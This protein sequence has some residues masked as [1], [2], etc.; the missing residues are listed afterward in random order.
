VLAVRIGAKVGTGDDTMTMVT[1]V[2]ASLSLHWI[3]LS[4]DKSSSEMDTSAVAGSA[5]MERRNPVWLRVRE[6]YR[7]VANFANLV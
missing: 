2:W 7:V 3:Q 5:S 6:L 4:G 1:P